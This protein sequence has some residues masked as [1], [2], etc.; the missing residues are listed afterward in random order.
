MGRSAAALFAEEP[1]RLFC[2]SLLLSAFWRLCWDAASDFTLRIL[3]LCGLISMVL[4]VTVRTQTQKLPNKTPPRA[5]VD[6][7][8]R[9]LSMSVL[10][11]LR[12]SALPPR[13]LRKQSSG[14]SPVYHLLPQEGGDDGTTHPNCM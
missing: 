2:L 8:R 4:G 6:L 5:S 11:P 3:T 9:R 12:L 13:S 1:R 14:L 7:S 10:S